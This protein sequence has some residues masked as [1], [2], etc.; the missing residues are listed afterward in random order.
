MI[1]RRF[2]S[3]SNVI[4]S[5]ALLPRSIPRR[6]LEKASDVGRMLLSGDI[7]KE[8]VEILKRERFDRY[9]S[10]EEREQFLATLVARAE[11]PDIRETFHVCRDPKDDKFLDL[12]VAG[13]ATCLITGDQDLLVLDAFR[14]IPIVTPR[15]FLDEFVPAEG[16][17]ASDGPSGKAP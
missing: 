1:E 3:D 8:L 13:Q 9:V 7:L 11:F 6:A 15:R 17:S 2:V 14:G 12:A 5:A 16:E 4:V 10:R